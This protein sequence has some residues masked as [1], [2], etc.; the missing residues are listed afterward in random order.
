MAQKTL[1][2]VN[3]EIVRW[4]VE[5]SGL[6][7]DEVASRSKVDAVELAG[8]VEGDG[9]PSR[10]EFTRLVEVL[11]RPSALFFAGRVPEPSPLP[12]MRSSPGQQVRALSEQER[13]WMRRSLRLQKLVSFLCDRWGRQVDLPRFGL[14]DPAEE[15]GER[16]RKW[17]GVSTDIQGLEGAAIWWRMWREQLERR[18]MLVFA[19]QLGGD[20]IRGFSVWDEFAPVISVNTAYNPAARIFT[21]FHELG[22]LTLRSGAACA[23]LR[24]V[25]TRRQGGVDEERWC[26]E[27]AAAALLPRLAVLEFVKAAGVDMEG[28]ELARK[29]ADRF[30]V[31]IR[32]AAIRLERLGAASGSIYALVNEKAPLW[33]RENWDRENW[34]RE[35]G[36]GRGKP[37]RRVRIRLDEYGAAAAEK[38]IYG[39]EQGLLNLRDL[40]DYLRLDR[41][42]VDEIARL[43]DTDG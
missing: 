35:K 26:E 12:A 14:D 7:M 29:A 4:A 38:L 8:W 20:G 27:A 3:G 23:D 24:F 32:A 28:F 25:G 15:A 39:S 10:G 16:L 13:L 33:D 36:F 9:K 34:D 2:P 30:G 42:E 11:K 17:L 22:H 19:L 6:S 18:G 5:E 41:T 37:R 31:S 1:V 21:A 43:V 40:S